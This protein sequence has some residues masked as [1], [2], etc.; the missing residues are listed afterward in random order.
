[1]NRAIVAVGIAAVLAGLASLATGGSVA[2]FDLGYAFVT[3]VG[4][5]ALVQGLRHAAERWSTPVEA[6]ETGDPER[7]HRVPTPGD[8]VDARLA[9][10]HDWSIRRSRERQTIRERL[11]DAAVDALVA[12]GLGDPEEADAR[13][14]AGAWTDDPFAAAFL[15][16]DAPVPP[17]SDRVRD[18]FR[19]GSRFE[20]DV[21][22]TV[23]AVE[24]IGEGDR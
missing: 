3:L 1:M 13:V 18:L 14:E 12:H 6:A 8:D 5:L 19:R 9:E 15:G 21:A 17:L 16:A 11:R 23:A 24:R 7:R 22:R 4:L 20:R 10:A 2:G